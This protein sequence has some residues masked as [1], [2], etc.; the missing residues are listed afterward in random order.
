[1][2]LYD[3]FSSIHFRFQTSFKGTLAFVGMWNVKK[4][5]LS[6]HGVL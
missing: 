1:M 4:G 6:Q 5:S 3:K 2:N